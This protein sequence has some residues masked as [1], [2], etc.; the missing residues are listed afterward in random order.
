MGRC[1]SRPSPSPQPIVPDDARARA[2][3]SRTATGINIR[4]ARNRNG[5]VKEVPGTIQCVFTER[6]HEM[7]ALC[8]PRFILEHPRFREASSMWQFVKHPT[9]TVSQEAATTTAFRTFVSMVPIPMLQQMLDLAAHE[10]GEEHELHNALC[11]E[12]N[13]AESSIKQLTQTINMILPGARGHWLVEM[14]Q[15]LKEIAFANPASGRAST[16]RRSSVV[17]A[18]Q[19]HSYSS[20]HDGNAHT[21]TW[22][23]QGFNEIQTGELWSS[24]FPCLRLSSLGSYVNK[25]VRV[26]GAVLRF[27]KEYHHLCQHRRFVYYYF[28][29][30][31]LPHLL[32]RQLSNVDMSDVMEHL[33]ADPENAT[34]PLVRVPTGSLSSDVFSVRTLLK[35]TSHLPSERLDRAFVLFLQQPN[36]PLGLLLQ[37]LHFALEHFHS[38]PTSALV[39]HCLVWLQRW[40]VMCALRLL[41]S[42]ASNHIASTDS[43]TGIPS[44]RRAKTAEYTSS[45]AVGG[46]KRRNTWKRQKT[47]RLKAPELG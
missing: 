22:L 38:T 2:S 12:A 1:H 44:L 46:R 33:Q 23:K 40:M 42:T 20:A 21:L 5:S 17:Y 13:F 8:V 24:T 16:A 19:E 30:E 4:P 3:L 25:Q 7:F 26:S 39:A 29:V 28:R 10:L 36:V 34:M 27:P 43:N 18:G 11:H 32:T 47:E 35:Q 31:W 45:A 6:Q 15:R 14:L 37:D 41:Q 9:A